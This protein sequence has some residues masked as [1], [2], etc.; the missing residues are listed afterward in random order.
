MNWQKAFEPRQEIIL[1]T[2][3]KDNSPH[4]I[5]VIS[6]GMI[7][8]KLLIGVSS[9]MKTTPENI[10]NNDKVVVVGKSDEGYFR[11]C[12]KAKI[13][14]S[15][16]YLQLA[17]IHSKSPLPKKTIVIDINEVYDINKATRIF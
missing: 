8:N 4:A 2:V 16:K 5:Y 1:A 15:G 13:Y 7:E 6:M 11:I 10:K 9:L 3:K 14:S 17:L 12:G